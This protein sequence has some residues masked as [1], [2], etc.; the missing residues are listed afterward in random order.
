[1]SSPIYT[2]DGAPLDPQNWQAA[3]NAL[4]AWVVEATGLSATSVV[5]SY[6]NAPERARPWAWL[7]V[8]SGPTADGQW[9]RRAGEQVMLET[10]TVPED[11]DADDYGVRLYDAHDGSDAGNLYVFEAIGTEDPEDVRDAL[12]ALLQS[13]PGLTVAAQGERS[14]TVEGTLSRKRWHSGAVGQLERVVTRDG[15]FDLIYQPQ[16]FTVRVQVEADGV[17]ADRLT[18]SLISRVSAW[19]GR[20]VNRSA[21]RQAGRVAH[22]SSEAPIN[23]SRQVGDRFVARTAQDFVFNIAAQLAADAPWVRTAT[24]EQTA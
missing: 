2:T 1:M 15:I 20:S 5:W 14:F 23:L 16:R 21:L 3:E 24:A 13:E 9:E 18:R 6:G 19:L 12:V 8:V 17:A 4:H 10:Y 11:V 22:R 7:D